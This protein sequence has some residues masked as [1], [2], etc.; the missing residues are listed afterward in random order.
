[1][2]L[3]LVRLMLLLSVIFAFSPAQS[4]AK[5]KGK[6]L[7]DGSST[8]FPITEAVAEE[9]RSVQPRV[10]VNIGVSGTG[11]G[12]KKFIAK[13]T[14]INDASR[15]IKDKEKILAKQYGIDYHVI[16]VAFDG[17]TVVVNPKNDWATDITAEELKKIWDRE[18]KVVTWADVRKGWPARKI[19]LY[20]PGTDS[21]T[22]DYFTKAING[23]SGRSRSNYTK[24]EDDNVLVRGVEGD[25]DAMGYFGYAYYKE[26]MKKL[27][28]VA[29]NGVRPNPE[30]IAKMSYK[31]LSRGIYIYVNSAS[32][33]RPEVKS[34]VDF[35]A[36]V[37]PEVVPEVGYVVPPAD[38]VQTALSAL[39]KA[40]K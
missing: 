5:L 27:K 25:L 10:R 7:I 11:G 24:S 31:P 19:K 6:V 28:A 37:L 33:K 12:F 32:Y 34:F 17:I 30:T 35:Y 2:K 15:K 8:V 3:N 29:V 16:P 39:Q 18:S 38:I 14:D 26:N 13:E 23:K 22:F 4:E 1:M 40:A 9:Y 20:G 21:G 36:K